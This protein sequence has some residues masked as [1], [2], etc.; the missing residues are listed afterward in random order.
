[1]QYNLARYLRYDIKRVFLMTK[2]PASQLIIPLENQECQ[3]IIL[4]IKLSTGK[5]NSLLQST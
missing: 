3:I 2:R 4:K 1:M 5:I